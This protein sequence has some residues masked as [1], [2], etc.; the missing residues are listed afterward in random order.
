MVG[1]NISNRV[2]H[3]GCEGRRVH[4]CGVG[5]WQTP[6]SRQCTRLWRPPGR[7]CQRQ[8]GTAGRAFCRAR[9]STSITVVEHMSRPKHHNGQQGGY[10]VAVKS[11][12]GA[13]ARMPQDKQ[14]EQR[15][16][17][18]IAIPLPVSPHPPPHPPSPD[19]ATHARWSKPSAL[20]FVSASPPVARL[21]CNQTPP[22]NSS[23][24]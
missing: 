22:Y 17:L 9:V 24:R 19:H 4:A 15:Q 21:C 13:A 6:W 11:G 2:L 10:R 12:A 14:Q 23:S 20:S 7:C 8:R 3:E 5:P 16:T 1:A 18:S